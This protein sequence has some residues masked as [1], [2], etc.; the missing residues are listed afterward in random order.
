M[1]PSRFDRVESVAAF[2]DQVQEF[3]TGASKRREAE[4]MIGDV[5]AR[6]SANR[7]RYADMEP[8]LNQLER[9]RI[10]WPASP[11]AE[12]LQQRLLLRYARAALRHGDLRLARIQA[13]RLT[14][15]EPRDDII[16]ELE[17]IERE[18]NRARERLEAAYRQVHE[19]RDRAKNAH[20]QADRLV[21]F[22]LEDLH[23]GL[24]EAGRLDL[25]AKAS[26]E[27]LHYFEASSDPT[28]TDRWLRNR[29][30][31]FRNIG[32][33][34]RAQGDLNEARRAFE[35]F[36]V[37]TVRLSETADGDASSQTLLAEAHERLSTALYYQGDLGGAEREQRVCLEIWEE[38]VRMDPADPDFEAGRAHA[39][40]LLGATWWRRGELDRARR[41]QEESLSVLERLCRRHSGQPRF[42]GMLAWNFATIANVHRDLGDLRQAIE[43][44]RRSI[45]IRQRLAEREP[46]NRTRWEDLCWSRTNLALLKEYAGDLENAIEAFREAEESQRRLVTNDPLNARQR[47]QLAFILTSLGRIYHNLERFVEAL[48]V[49]DEGH[50]ISRELAQRDMTNTRECGGWVLSQAHLGQAL[51]S[52]GDCGQASRFIASAMPLA[53]ELHEKHPR[54]GVL[55]NALCQTLLLKGMI[56]D[57][58][59]RT[60]DAVDDWER[61]L[62]C[63]GEQGWGRST[64]QGL[65]L[66]AD[67]QL[68]LGLR[69]EAAASIAGLRRMNWMTPRL[70]SLASRLGLKTDG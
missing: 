10:L 55:H 54:N 31:A 46:G 1:K 13:S 25:L 28:T 29:A 39:L 8:L 36:Q 52:I 45:E 6:L 12:A 38:L 15:S 60:S 50:A 20:A 49:L 57:A 30:I 32:D 3:L 61:A 26:R 59:G 67:L 48:Q 70:E 35:R 23:S 18:Q 69:E 22:L 63:V 16:A 41:M 64:A 7:L 24:E 44:T 65:G 58:E 34:F 17:R 5:S 68:R 4:R 19:E 11:D 14:E 40:H 33:V 27:A 56:A 47:N 62:E 2:R 43:A 37:L 42:E 21:T 51:V 53:E 9:A 66:V